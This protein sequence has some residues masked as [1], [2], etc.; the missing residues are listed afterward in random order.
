MYG[1]FI[2]VPVIS[3][4]VH[5]PIVERRSHEMIHWKLIVLNIFPT[6]SWNAPMLV[7]WH[8]DRKDWDDENAC[9]NKDCEEK[10]RVRSTY[11][12]HVKRHRNEKQPAST[13][14]VCVLQNCQY[15]TSNKASMKQHL[16]KVHDYKQEKG[17]SEMHSFDHHKLSM[18]GWR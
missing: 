18:R 16:T 17:K 13:I 9:L 4:H 5:F 14:Y 1:R 12:A 10:F 15:T 11:H 8:L 7:S 6:W 3:L 2:Y